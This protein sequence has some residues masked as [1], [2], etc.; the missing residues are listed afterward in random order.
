[1]IRRIQIGTVAGIDT[2]VWISCACP[3]LLL[4]VVYLTWVI[5]FLCLGH[6]PTGTIGEAQALGGL[7]WLI[8]YARIVCL[9][10]CIPAAIFG[11]FFMLLESLQRCLHG[12]E[13]DAALIIVIP[14]L[15]WGFT[16]WLLTTD[17]LDVLF[18]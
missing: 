15:I 3:V 14:I 1:M 8:G 18:I 16:I 2:M 12:R 11:A 9:I 5:A 10:I 6:P 7:N 4:F 17:P 13:R